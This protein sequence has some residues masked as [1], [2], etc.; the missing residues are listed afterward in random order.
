MNQANN[1]LEDL[2]VKLYAQTE[3]FDVTIIDSLV[4]YAMSGDKYLV[5]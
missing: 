3:Q 5:Y 4:Q 1:V 2:K